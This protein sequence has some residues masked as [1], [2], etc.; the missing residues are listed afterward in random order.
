MRTKKAAQSGPYTVDCN[1]VGGVH[2]RDIIYGTYIT[3]EYNFICVERKLDSP[4]RKPI[5]EGR[6]IRDA[7]DN[8][9]GY[10]DHE[11]ELESHEGAALV[12]DAGDDNG[13][14]RHLPRHRCP[15]VANRGHPTPV[16]TPTAP[17]TMLLSGKS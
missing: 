12:R 15:V 14:S 9:N 7:G 5:A 3:R 4:D 6:H 11:T 16:T 1:Y 17:P 2:E 8:D 13:S 10:G